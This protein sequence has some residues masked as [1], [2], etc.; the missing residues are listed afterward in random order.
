MVQTR[1]SAESELENNHNKIMQMNLSKEDLST[2]LNGIIITHTKPLLDK[3]AQLQTEIVYLKQ[4]NIDMVKL[5]TKNSTVHD[6]V[7]PS[8]ST[9]VENTTIGAD[10]LDASLDSSCSG[11]TVVSWTTVNP[12]NKRPS[13]KKSNNK[14]SKA[15]IGKGPDHQNEGEVLVAA[16]K[17][18]WLYVGRIKPTIKPETIKRYLDNKI[19][20]R[21]FTVELVKCDTSAG[22]KVSADYDLMSTL[23]TETFWPKNILIKRFDFFRYK[24]NSRNTYRRP[25]KN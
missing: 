15:I 12:I 16:P 22:F 24:K 2:L 9:V 5:L 8:Y 6:L 11:D 13:D 1:N 21:D 25:N 19:P 4:S 3:I 20:N 17:K 14:K 7:K 10:G 18:I 23:Y